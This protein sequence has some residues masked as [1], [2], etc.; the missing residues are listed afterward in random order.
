MTDDWP[1][2]QVQNCG[3]ITLKSIIFEG[4]PILHV[5]HDPEDHGWQFLGWDD[6]EREDA[7]L[8]HL[9]EVDALDPTLREIARM[10]PGWHAWRRRREDPWTIERI[11]QA[12][13]DED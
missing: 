10:L 3:V 6:P 5:F 2:D 11:P 4:A 8:V 9:S 7:A 1:W 13:D 12:P